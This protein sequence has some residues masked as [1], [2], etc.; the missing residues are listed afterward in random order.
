M[1]AH[2]RAMQAYYQARGEDG[3]FYTMTLPGMIRVIQAAGRLIRT[4]TDTGSLLLIDQRFRQ[5]QTR[6]LLDGTLIGAALALGSGPVAKRQLSQI[7]ASCNA[8]P[9]NDQ[10]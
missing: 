1:D 10:H 3:F 7:Q 5:R 2:I 8:A 9:A 4:E 6:S